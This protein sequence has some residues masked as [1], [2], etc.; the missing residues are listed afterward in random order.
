MKYYQSI[1]EGSPCKH[2]HLNRYHAECCYR[3]RSD[4]AWDENPECC[5]KEHTLNTPVFTTLSQMSNT[6][7]RRIAATMGLDAYK[8]QLAEKKAQ[9]L[10]LA[11][12]A[13]RYGDASRQCWDWDEYWREDIDSPVLDHTTED[14]LA[15]ENQRCWKLCE[16]F[17]DQAVELAG[18]PIWDEEDLPR[19]VERLFGAD[20]GWDEMDR[21]E[22]V[23]PVMDEKVFFAL[24]THIHNL[25]VAG[26]KEIA[27]KMTV[28]AVW[29]HLGQ[30]VRQVSEA[31][32]PNYR[33][34]RQWFDST[35]EIRKT[36]PYVDVFYEEGDL[37]DEH[38]V[39]PTD[40]AA[41]ALMPAELAIALQ[42]SIECTRAKRLIRLR[43]ALHLVR[44]KR[45]GF[46]RSDYLDDAAKS[47]AKMVMEFESFRVSKAALQWA[48]P[49]SHDSNGI[50]FTFDDATNHRYKFPSDEDI[51]RVVFE[52]AAHYGVGAYCDNESRSRCG[53]AKPGWEDRWVR[54]Y[55]CKDEEPM[56]SMK[57]AACAGA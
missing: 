10:F 13:Y 57:P 30:L 53:P 31:F 4:A 45:E 11:E 8:R 40:E 24:H 2:L 18:T 32:S 22:C 23:K 6:Q 43:G 56:Y 29:R 15:D 16:A 21:G 3:L 19:W 47:L 41:M 17:K 38:F 37:I 7:R 34:I 54:D 26:Q 28:S 42:A 27:K 5:V 25:W 46:Y 44:E 51:E 36:I 52:A 49:K 50:R 14:A 39:R 9:I 1:F 12:K 35:R 48:L 33:L 20:P 55:A